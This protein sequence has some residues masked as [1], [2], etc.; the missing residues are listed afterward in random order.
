M[1]FFIFDTKQ[2]NKQSLDICLTKPDF[3]YHLIQYVY[4]IQYE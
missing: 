3:I 4:K 2:I 1:Y